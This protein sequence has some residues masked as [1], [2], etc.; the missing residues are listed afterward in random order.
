MLEETGLA[1]KFIETARRVAAL[2][3]RLDRVAFRE[4]PEGQWER[5]A[6]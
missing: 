5:R 6:A 3:S 2:E 4:L 1:P